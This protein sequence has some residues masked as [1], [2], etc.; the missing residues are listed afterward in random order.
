MTTNPTITAALRGGWVEYRAG[1]R[2]Q[3]GQGWRTVGDGYFLTD[4][5][6]LLDPLLAAIRAVTGRVPELSTGG[7]T[8]DARFICPSRQIAR[9]V[10]GSQS[11]RVY[12]YFFKHAYDNNPVFTSAATANFA[13][14]ASG[15]VLTVQAS[16]ADLPAQTL[17][18]SISGGV[19]AAKFAINAT[20]GALSFVSSPNA[21]SPTDVGANN[22]YDVIVQVSDG[23]LTDTQ[24]I[25]VTVSDL[26]DNAPNITSDGG[27]AT[28]AAVASP[29]IAAIQD[30]LRF[31]PNKN[32][33]TKIGAAAA[34]ADRPILSAIGV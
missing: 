10:A 12:R 34:R 24:A 8:S 7:G 23:T 31:T 16:D 19:D 20:T 13:E 30:G 32:R 33:R 2:V 21:E 26:N 28:A 14:N 11:E 15:T 5:G 25:A 27:N 3:V 9:A 29:A 22:V 4:A 17:S 18:Y 6:R 1:E